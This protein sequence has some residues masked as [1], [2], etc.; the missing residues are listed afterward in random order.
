VNRFRQLNDKPDE[1]WRLICIRYILN[2][3][4]YPK[5]KIDTIQ[6]LMNWFNQSQR[7]LWYDSLKS[8]SI[9]KR[10]KWK[11]DAVNIWIDSYVNRF[12]KTV[13]RFIVILSGKLWIDSLRYYSGKL[14][15]DSLRHYSVKFDSIQKEWHKENGQKECLIWNSN[16]AI[17][18]RIIH[19]WQHTRYQGITWHNETW[20]ARCFNKFLS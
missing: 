9:Q 6:T 12:K 20:F 16:Q 1:Q 18:R 10:K 17:H 13:K 5:M 11:I 8:E 7:V 3:F 14:W 2:R 4:K 15:I 19:I